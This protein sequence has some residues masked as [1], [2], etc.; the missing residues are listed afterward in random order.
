METSDRP[1]WRSRAWI[2]AVATV[3]AIALGGSLVGVDG[4]EQ[5]WIP[6]AA[7]SAIIGAVLVATLLRVR[8]ERRAHEERLM[9][10]AAERAA[11]EERLRIARELHDLA[12]HGL[13]LITV[14]AAAATRSPRTSEH[15]NAL[16]DIEGAARETMV[17]L[18][19]MLA[20]LRS[21]A[22]SPLEPAPLRPAESLAELSDIVRTAESL[23]LRVSL[24]APTA[25]ELAHLSP[26]TQLTACA[27]LREALVNAARY[28]GPTHVEVALAL[29]DDGGLALA[30]HDH[31]PVAGW[32]ASPGAGFGL[33]GLRERAAA[34]GG[35][36]AARAAGD[37]FEL[38]AHLP[39]EGAA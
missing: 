16:R 24:S 34:L 15:A 25:E 29:P 18:R 3:A 26:G 27:I 5:A 28:A 19:R 20:V 17:E 12:S 22:P 21:P 11:Q 10:W 23:G 38:S 8:R 35:S 14:R 4:P 9:A 36:L 7:L 2:P 39:D 33:A 37:G 6:L 13:G 30:V 32:I 1:V 31:G